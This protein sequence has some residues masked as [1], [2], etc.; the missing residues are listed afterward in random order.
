[1][2]N[3]INNLLSRK[4]KKRILV[5]VLSIL[6]LI[7]AVACALPFVYMLFMSL[8]KDSNSIFQWPPK[9]IPDTFHFDNFIKAFEYI[10][11]G[12]LIGNTLILVLSSM[13][14]GI[15]SSILVAYGFARMRSKYATPLFSLLLSTMMIPWVV[16]MIPAYTEFE[17]LGWIGTRL[18]LIIPWIGGSAF[19][20]FMLRQFIMGIPRELDEAAKID[21]C[22]SFTILIRIILPQLK[23]VLA[24]LL[25]FS[26][27][28]TW[29]DYVGPSI[30]LQDSNLHTLSLGMQ[31]F[32]SATGTANWAQVMAASIIF[33]VPM[34]L[35]LFFAQKAFVRG[36]VNTGF[37]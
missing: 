19:N 10:D 6:A 2:K 32:F 26:F 31:S 37:K 25:V 13:V 21:G 18:P 35:V 4:G 23:P 7:I 15:C 33:S 5:I 12:K 16:T 30:Y 11:M 1:M 3:I 34:V 20:I 36:V 28:N 14:I 9:I 27:I 17:Y 24:T 29:S 22:N 8:H